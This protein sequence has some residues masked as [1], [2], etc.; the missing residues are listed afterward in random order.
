MGTITAGTGLISGLDTKSIID[1]LVAIDGKQKDLVQAKVD[2]ATA[3]K[4]AYVD[5]TTRLTGLQITSQSLSKPSFFAN[6]TATSSDEDVATAV[7]AAGAPVGSYQFRVARLV[8]AQQMVTGT[9]GDPNKA[10]P[11]AGKITV[12]LGGGQVVQPNNLNDLRGGAGITRGQMRVTDRAGHST[13]IDLSDAVTLDDV[14]KKFNTAVD[15]NVKASVINNKLTLTDATALATGKLIV[16]DVGTTTSAA[17]LGIA[18]TT[19]TTGTITGQSLNFIGLQTRLASLNDGNGVGDP[20]RSDFRVNVRGG[21]H[22]DVDLR[23][24]VTIGDAIKQIGDQTQNKVVASINA[25]GTGLKLTDKTNGGGTFSTESINGTTTAADLGL[26]GAASGGTL[27]GSPV[28]AALGTVLL[29]NLNGGAGL[30]GLDIL[31]VVKRNGTAVDADL[32]TAK[33]LQDVIDK[34]NTAAGSAIAG[35]NA[36]GNGLQLTD[37]SGTGNLVV[38]DTDGSTATKLGLGG[39]FTAAQAVVSGANL[40]RKWASNAMPLANYNGGKGVS[41]GD[42]EIAAADGTK[43]TISIDP[44]KDLTLGDVIA[45]INAAAKTTVTPPALPTQVVT[46]GINATGDGLMLTDNSGGPGVMVVTEKG[47][48]T[49]ANLN[50]LGKST[51]NVINGSMEK[52]IDVAA[53][54]TLAMVQKKIN[55]LSWGLSATVMNDG[56]GPNAYRLALNA[57]NAGVAGQVTFDA[58]QTQL[59]ARTLVKAQ[60]AAVFVGSSD[61]NQPLLITSNKNAVTNAVKGVTL[62][63][64]SVS[65]KPVTISVTP[66]VKN[67]TDALQTFVDA[68]NELTDKIDAYTS[69]RA[70]NDTSDDALT[71]DENGNKIDPNAGTTT[72]TDAS[73]N[74]FRRGILLGDYSINQVQDRLTQMLQTVVPQAGKYRILERVGL[75]LDGD[76]KMQFDADKF[77]AAYAD[78]PNSV[79]SLF[80]QTGAAI[81]NDTELRYL[82]DGKGISSAGVGQDDFKADLKDGTN[83]TVS[84]N[85]ANT[86]G[87]IIKSI[88]AAGGGGKLLAEL[89]TDYKLVI[90]DL[91]T[92][93]HDSTLNLLNGSQALANLGMTTTAAG[94]KFTTRRLASSDPLASA[95]GG[96]GVSFQK[97]INGLINPVDGLIA[98]ENKSIDD[99]ITTFQGRISDLNILL[100]QKRTRLERQFANLENVLAKLKTQQS[101]LS[102]IGSSAA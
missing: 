44:T 38:S 64:V 79:K 75:S 93:T 58:G 49:A 80:T 89:G 102:S 33:T 4:T 61:T 39:T 68:Y 29:K 24:A 97:A 3:Q 22:F 55:D 81:N 86:M 91:T 83:V 56:S 73:G 47:S 69:F 28:Q 13:I 95:T 74:T 41:A 20:P 78:D 16:Q 26:D 15:V 72:T 31:H 62:N 96:V 48:S 11:G 21:Y 27:D 45:K 77:N 10:L 42:F 17:D 92:G 37:S 6:A 8:Q 100:D 5:L 46:A 94:G 23:N 76:G 53:T 51:A 63:L 2:Q 66:D 90:T 59:S 99:K 85:G 65:D 32:S 88:N 67:V 18:T 84:L 82:N 101:S 60:D 36:S 57:S 9:F 1:Q 35:V 7:A 40:Q 71:A 14:V 98:G 43:Y 30:T 50:L 25:D 70:D 34:I 19:N 12:E 52:T 54:D 87:D